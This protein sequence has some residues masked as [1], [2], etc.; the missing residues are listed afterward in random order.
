MERNFTFDLAGSVFT[1]AIPC[2]AAGVT[3]ERI[4]VQKE[5]CVRPMGE[6]SKE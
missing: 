4:I 2:G 5:E 6:L 3:S 1:T